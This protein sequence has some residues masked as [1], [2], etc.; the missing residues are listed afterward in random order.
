MLKKISIK[1]YRSLKNV[2]LDL[3]QLNVLIGANNSG[4]SNLLK[5]LLFLKDLFLGKIGQNADIRTFVF[6]PNHTLTFRVDNVYETSEVEKVL[7][8]YQ[9]ELYLKLESI[10]KYAYFDCSEFVGKAK[11][12]DIEDFSLSDSKYIGE[13]FTINKIIEHRKE[14]TSLLDEYFGMPNSEYPLLLDLNDLFKTTGDKFIIYQPNPSRLTKAYPLTTDKFVNEDASNLVAFLDNMRDEFPEIYR[15]IVSDL[16]KC[17]KDFTDLRFQKVELS[18][19]S[20]EIKLH[21]KQTFKKFGLLDKFGVIYWSEEL[22]EGTLYFLALLAILHQPD[23]PKL[24]LLEEPERGIH[25]RRIK[26]VINFIL[27]LAEIKN[28][29]VILT[30]HSPTVLDYFRDFPQSVFVFDK[31]EEGA[32]LIKNLEKD[33]LIPKEDE[34]LKNNRQP[35]DYTRD[36][37]INWEMGFFGGVPDN[38]LSK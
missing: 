9:V 37:G 7:E 2:S 20:E 4:K 13:H 26:E 29:Q 12:L 27:D 14:H 21:G 6:N 34:E 23:P 16:H 17:V 32:T 36:M 10:Y 5:A 19:E 38:V 8:V 18:E 22:S 1:N 25:P 15:A 3:Q 31:D 24:L 33:I 11:S 35:V 28:I 30:T